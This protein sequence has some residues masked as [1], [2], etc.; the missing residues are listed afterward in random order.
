M[1]VYVPGI[2]LCLQLD[3]FFLQGRPYPE[4]MKILLAILVFSFTT[5]GRAKMVLPKEIQ[6]GPVIK[7]A[8]GNFADGVK[9]LERLQDTTELGNDGHIA[10][11]NFSSRAL[12]A[13][14]KQKMLMEKNRAKRAY[15][16]DQYELA[17]RNAD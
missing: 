2:C 3:P 13:L 1:I 11:Y 4:F 12:A 14:Y 10:I 6:H 7:D 16:K 17:C 15:Y 9:A 5:D 8:C